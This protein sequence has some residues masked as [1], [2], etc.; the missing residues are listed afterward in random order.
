MQTIVI[1]MLICW[2]ISFIGFYFREDTD[3]DGW[4]FLI[5]PL[6]IIPYIIIEIHESIENSKRTHY[7]KRYNLNRFHL[8]M[9]YNKPENRY[10][11][12]VLKDNFAYPD[13]EIELY[14]GNNK[15][16][17]FDIYNKY[18]NM[19]EDDLI[20]VFNREEAK[21]EISNSNDRNNA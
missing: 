16:E 8:W 21:Y 2:V 20:T 17:A 11:V 7:I 14:N 13:R 5:S 19:T 3:R 12:K 18:A 4:I 6:Y 15:K 9:N 1:T 10:W